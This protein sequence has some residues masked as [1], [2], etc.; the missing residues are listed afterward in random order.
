MGD[1][2]MNREYQKIKNIFKFDEK[3]NLIKCKC[4]YRDMLKSGLTNE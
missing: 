4:K 1:K 3:H 2:K